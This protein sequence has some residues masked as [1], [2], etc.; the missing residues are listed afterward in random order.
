MGWVKSR[1]GDAGFGSRGHPEADLVL[2]R[3]LRIRAAALADPA[4]AKPNLAAGPAQTVNQ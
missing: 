1:A 2:H 3:R 4:P